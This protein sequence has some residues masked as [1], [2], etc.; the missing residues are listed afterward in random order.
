MTVIN[1][2]NSLDFSLNLDVRNINWKL[3]IVNNV[4]SKQF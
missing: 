1:I 3:L 2:L 4:A